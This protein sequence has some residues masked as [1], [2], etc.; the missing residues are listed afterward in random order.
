MNQGILYIVSTPIGNLEDITLRALRVL[1]EVD[2]IAAEDTRRTRHLLTH[3]GIHKPLV[4]YHEHNRKSREESLIRELTGGKKIALV[5]D[6]GTPGISD[7][8]EDLVRRAVQD[9][10]PL[11][12]IPGPA[13]FV[14]ALCISGLPTHSFLFNGFLPAKGAARRKFLRSL[15]DRKETLLFYESPKRIHSFLAE[16]V[17]VFGERRAVIAREIT[18]LHEQVYRGTIGEVF[19]Q[20]GEA[21]LRGEVTIAIAGALDP[22]TPATSGIPEALRLYREEGELS[23]KEA[24]ERV[25][26]ELR[27]PK[28]QVYQESL[29]LKKGKE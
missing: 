5:T 6:A 26:A 11:V 3:Y 1:K 7:P 22:E 29:Q 28:R 10:I 25:A 18:K 16:A 9:G 24:I 20:I 8:G 12:P 27:V 21:E 4:S 15:K 23:M 13:A 2:L 14:A 19:A 17:E